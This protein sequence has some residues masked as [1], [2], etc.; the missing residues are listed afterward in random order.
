MNKYILLL[1]LSVPFLQ[2]M[3]NGQKLADHSVGD[4]HTC[5]YCAQLLTWPEKAPTAPFQESDDAYDSELEATDIDDWEVEEEPNFDADRKRSTATTARDASKIDKGA[6]SLFLKIA[7]QLGNY[8]NVAQRIRRGENVSAQ[9][10]TDALKDLLET[11]KDRLDFDA[12]QA[13]I[14]AAQDAAS[15][16][17]RAIIEQATKD[18]EQ[19]QAKCSNRK[20]IR[21]RLRKKV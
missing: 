13:T 6:N 2:G 8:E 20:I 15:Q 21:V 17:M 19:E 4:L 3:E 7:I 16:K 10:L 11:V 18:W 12:D 9:D 14:Q 1:I 5:A